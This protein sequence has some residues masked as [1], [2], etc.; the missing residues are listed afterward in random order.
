M[1]SSEQQ[2][3]QREAAL[4][5]RPAHALAHL[6]ADWSLDGGSLL[7]RWM[8]MPGM[9]LLL[10]GLLAIGVVLLAGCAGP[11]PFSSAPPV[12]RDDDRHP[13]R[14]KPDDSFVPT[15]WDGADHILFRPLSHAFLLQ[16]PHEAR[17]VNALDEV[18]D[19]SWFTARI[20]R[21]PMTVEEVARGACTDRSPVE[22]RPWKVMGVKID[23]A[24]PGF[25][26]T[27]SS[28]AV[29]V[30]KFDDPDQWGRA[31]TADMVG[32]RL[33]HAAG[34]HVP[35]NRVVF[36]RHEE[37]QL[38][39]H[40]IKD[41]GGKTLTRERIEEMLRGLPREPDGTIRVLASQF[42]KGKPL[43]PWNYS[44][45]WGGDPNDVIPHEDRRE[46]RGSRI[47]G[48]WIDHH[49][50]RSQNTLAMWIDDGE[51]R[52][53]VEHDILD[54]GDTLGGLAPWDSISR[55][56]G[57]TY[58]IDFGAIGADFI[59]FGA[60]SRPWE[61]AKFGP[62][63]K[64]FGYFNDAEFE[65]QDWHVG[66]PNPAFS[67][68]QE[69]DGAWMARVISH[70][71]DADIEAIVNEAHLS[72]PVAHSE[73]IRILRGRRDRIFRR[74]LLRLSSLE[75]PVVQD[76]RVLV[77]LTSLGSAIPGGGNVVCVEDRAE[78]AGLGAAPEP[79]AR[80]WYS[81]N[82]GAVLPISHRGPAELCVAIPDLG[83]AQRVLDVS[84]GRPG[85]GPLRI[86]LLGGASPRVVGLE[87][88]EN[89]YPPPG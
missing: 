58:Y 42:L 83:D 79:S 31:S 34:F 51:G 73:L 39:E 18:P 8:L 86:H 60:V 47:L 20:G 30:L 52:G 70:L 85:Q 63:G 40:E 45:V 46:L 88:P 24:N 66:Y 53:H 10:L 7:H 69:S 32:S 48:A 4:P 14:P 22:E 74:Y 84:T 61:R 9:A 77:R 54:W 55:R 35:C 43:G 33:Y 13:F 76:G 27:T 82:T 29:Y 87:R 80:L 67:A 62:A 12:W 1:H 28:G 26:I 72:S 19:S 21:R 71:D 49:D 64:I 3:A 16:T 41:P 89:D 2:G 38:P 15:Y 78:S 5:D 50:A 68:M 81:S 65:P 57:Y 75:R 37:L 44:G 25:R 36:L 23:G 17:N 11:R 6:T 56:I 59:T